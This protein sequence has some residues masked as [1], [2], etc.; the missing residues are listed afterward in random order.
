M[1]PIERP[2]DRDRGRLAQQQRA[3]PG[4][5]NGSAARART[6]RA[7]IRLAAAPQGPRQTASGREEIV[8]RLH[9]VILAVVMVLASGCVATPD[10]YRKYQQPYRSHPDL[11]RRTK[12]VKVVGVLPPDIK[13]YELSAGGVADLRDDWSATGRQAV[14]RGLDDVLKERG[15]AL[16]ALSVDRDMQGPVEDL[17]ALYRAVSYSIVEHTYKSF[18]FQAKLENFDYSVGPVDEM[19]K[20]Y[21]AD[22]FLLVFGIDEISTAGRKAL[23]GV[24]LVLGSVTGQPVLSQ[25]TTALNLALVDRSG[26]VLWYKIAGQDGGYDLRD[27]KSAKAF[28]QRLVADFPSVGR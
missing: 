6:D 18:P 14:L 22:A 27:A 10:W 17:T 19:L 11:E 8:V 3:A 21:Q 1:A 13:I 7:G 28:V 4:N 16:K 9:S 2:V 20:R 12:A 23:R 15:V 25:G 26:A 5:P 24:G